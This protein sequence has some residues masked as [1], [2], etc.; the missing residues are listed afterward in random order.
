[1]VQRAI[2]SVLQQSLRDLEVIVV[3]DGSTD[4]TGDMVA[5]L[6]DP[7]VRYVYQDNA[8]APEARNAGIRIATGR[9]V[10]FL[11]S[12]DEWLP[13]KMEIQVAAAANSPVGIVL[14]DAIVVSEASARRVSPRLSGHVYE[15][16]L[17]LDGWSVGAGSS[18]VVPRELANRV[19]FDPDL[20]AF[21]DWDFVCRLSQL[22]PVIS[23][24]E[25]LVLIHHLGNTERIWSGHR[26]QAATSYVL[27]KY[28]A[29]F[30][31]H[32]EAGAN[33]AR[34][35]SRRAWRLG[36]MAGVRSGLAEL[37]KYERSRVTAMYAQ[38][39]R[40]GSAPF[41]VALTIAHKL[42]AAM[43]YGGRPPVFRLRPW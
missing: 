28:A 33:F 19:L 10:A 29:E 14:C 11:D 37:S 13:R 39:A 5:G 21:Q 43:S 26:I 8:G 25:P 1:M 20:V 34:V 18:V 24:Q 4:G 35:V 41:R 6:D 3:D 42:E 2:I 31:R 22:A 32:P 16:V 15:A 12:D 7:R 36:D 9:F 30:R 40:H 17:G 38:L 27:D 23:V